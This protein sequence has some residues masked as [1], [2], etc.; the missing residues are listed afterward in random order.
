MYETIDYI[1]LDSMIKDITLGCL[2]KIIEKKYKYCDVKISSFKNDL[3]SLYCQFEQP[4]N[5]TYQDTKN[6]FSFSDIE[7]V[8]DN[9]LVYQNKK[10]IRINVENNE[11]N[12]IWLNEVYKV[13]SL[14]LDKTLS[15]TNDDVTKKLILTK[16]EVF[17]LN[18]KL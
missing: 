5:S 17:Q 8:F 1:E 15:L 4:L 16:K 6:N 12:N 9:K 2:G 13:Y 14:F 18:H 7:V 11:Y 3:I 10:G